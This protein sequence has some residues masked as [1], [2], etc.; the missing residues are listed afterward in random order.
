MKCPNCNQEIS[1]QS[2][3][4]NNCGAAIE[5][6]EDDVTQSDSILEEKSDQ[7]PETSMEKNN[8]D[9]NHSD[10][11]SAV[12]E[13]K[14]KKGKIIVIIAVFIVCVTALI[15]FLTL[16]CNHQWKD[17]TCISPK[18]CS[19]CGKEKGE[20]LGHDWREATCTDAQICNRC[21]A[22]G[23]KALGHDVDFV[24]VKEASCT[25]AGEEKGTCKRCNKEIEKTIDKIPHEP[26]G[27]WVTIDSSD[28]SFEIEEVQYCTM[29]GKIART[30]TEPMTEEQ[31]LEKLKKICKSYTFKE[32][33]RNPES[34]KGKYAYYKGEVEQ[35]VSDETEDEYGVYRINITYD[36]YWTDAIMVVFEGKLSDGSRLIEEDV[37]KMYGKLD[38]TYTY[39]SIFGETITVPLFRAYYIE[40]AN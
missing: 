22:V 38:G 16:R 40:R 23:A 27:K 36:D 9:A 20:A 1:D 37:V 28:D 17:A 33:S 13:K 30:R 6:K 26:S 25:E 21:F 5:Q 4:C 19:L 39:E 10:D 11:D 7:N 2:K 35:V 8:D 15:L 29:C 14:S 12:T 34:Y 31:K 18:T 3:F 32:I 24:V